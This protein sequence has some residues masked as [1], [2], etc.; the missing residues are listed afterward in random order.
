MN[1]I[2]IVEKFSD[3]FR[4]FLN[5]KLT[6]SWRG[7]GNLKVGSKV[8]SLEVWVDGEFIPTSPEGY[9]I[10]RDSK[11]GILLFEVGDFEATWFVALTESHQVDCDE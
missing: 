5:N 8:N 3:K 2:Q 6:Q 11:D 7:D 9:G 4:W 1:D 10:L